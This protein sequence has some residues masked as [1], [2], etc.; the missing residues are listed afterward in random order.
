MKFNKSYGTGD[1]SNGSGTAPI[2]LNWR[3]G[4]GKLI[5]K[6]GGTIDFDVQ[7]CNADLQNGET[8]NWA[9]ASANAGLTGDSVI[10]FDAPPR[11]IRIFVNSTTS[12]TLTLDYTQADV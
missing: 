2:A 4:P 12:G 9:A 5:I 8:A 6:K 3:G 7:E 11:F 10:T 1:L